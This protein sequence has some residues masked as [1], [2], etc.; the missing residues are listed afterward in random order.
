M[1]SDSQGSKD[2]SIPQR[3]RPRVMSLKR[4]QASLGPGRGSLPPPETQCLQREENK[5]EGFPECQK[6]QI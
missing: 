4:A 3:N 2:L 6:Q 5:V 1:L